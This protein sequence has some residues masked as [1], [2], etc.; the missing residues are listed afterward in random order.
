MIITPLTAEAVMAPTFTFSVQLIA[1]I[2]L[3]I[4]FT[5]AAAAASHYKLPLLK[6]N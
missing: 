2:Y 5:E 3:Y 6:V 4:N 1:M